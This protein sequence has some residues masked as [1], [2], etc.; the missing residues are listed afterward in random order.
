V[1]NHSPLRADAPAL[2]VLVG[3]LT[4][5]LGL[6]WLGARWGIVGLI[7]TAGAAYL[8]TDRADATLGWLREGRDVR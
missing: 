7:V 5:V 6:G 1:T 8:V 4:V 3:W 2:L